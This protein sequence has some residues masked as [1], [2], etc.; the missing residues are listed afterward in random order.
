[1]CII[2]FI[3]DQELLTELFS[4]LLCDVVVLQFESNFSEV[5][6]ELMK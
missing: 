4:S 6:I 2:E 1:M 5:P 3:L